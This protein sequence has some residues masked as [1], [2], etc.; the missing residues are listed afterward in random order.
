MVEGAEGLRE[1]REEGDAVGV[2]GEEGFVEVR[3]DECREGG[4]GEGGVVFGH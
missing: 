1:G 2:V 4:G 3:V